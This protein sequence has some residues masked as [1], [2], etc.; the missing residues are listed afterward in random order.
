VSDRGGG[1]AGGRRVARRGCGVGRDGATVGT[2]DDRADATASDATKREGLRR[3]AGK[4]RWMNDDEGAP[5]S[6]PRASP[7]APPGARGGRRPER[8]RA[9]SSPRRSGRAATPWRARN[10][11]G[12]AASSSKKPTVASFIVRAR[13]SDARTEKIS[14]ASSHF[15]SARRE[16]GSPV[17]NVESSL[18]RHGSRRRRGDAV[19]DVGDHR[20]ATRGPDLPQ[21]GRVREAV[22]RRD[23]ARPHRSHRSPYDRVGVVHADPQ[24]LLPL[25]LSAHTSLTIPTRLDAFQLHLT[26][27]DSTPTFARTLERTS[28]APRI[29]RAST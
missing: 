29:S 13:T 12:V 18:A 8:S 1:R 23:Q 15:P 26:P 5:C 21:R 14:L 6:T 16:R 25:F 22:V 10:G 7:S 17:A 2:A 19:L 3:D 11:G 27:F 9:A 20:G 28:S 4:K 24:G